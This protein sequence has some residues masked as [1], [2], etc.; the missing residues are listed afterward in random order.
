MF[1]LIY[2]DDSDKNIQTTLVQEVDDVLGGSVPTY[3]T[4]KNLKFVEAWYDHIS[5]VPRTNKALVSKLTH[6]IVNFVYVDSFY[7]GRVRQILY[8]LYVCPLWRSDMELTVLL[9][10]T[11]S[12]H[13]VSSLQF[14]VT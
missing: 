1:Y 11:C 6:R 3:E 7:E 9:V 14:P 5:K 4:F 10:I 13:Y 12:Q 8:I 2:R